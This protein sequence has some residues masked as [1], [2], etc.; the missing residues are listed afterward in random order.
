MIVG[1]RTALGDRLGITAPVVQAP[2]GS[3]AAP[4]LAAAV[5]EAGGLG[6]LAVTWQGPDRAR[7]S[8]REVRRRTS[9]P[10]GVNLILDFPVQDTL[11]VCL[12][13][14]VPVVSTFWGD[15]APVSQLI[16]DGGA[17]HMHTVGSVRE[18]QHSVDCDVDVIVAQGWEGGGHVRG[19]T[20]TMVL[21]P[22]VVDAVSP[23]PVMAAGGISDGRGVAAALA[24]GAQ[25]VWLGTRFLATIEARTHQ[26]YRNRLVASGA[27]DTVHTRCFDG[28][29]P[30]APHRVLRNT[31]VHRWESAGSPP[32]PG[33]PGD[34]DIV[35]VDDEGQPHHRYEDLIPLPGMTGDL[36]DMALY[37][38]QSVEL[39]RDV[40]PAGQLI[41]DLT[42][43]TID[44][45]EQMRRMT[46]PAHG[47]PQP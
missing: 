32:S 10:F 36:A 4:E 40:R 23:I 1:L 35:A 47:S 44:A 6:M 38:G 5:S 7:D 33:R 28:G 15:P 3:A 13:E 37:A 11:A 20:T 14:A 16:R 26:L 31:T 17:L 21:V 46:R 19:T 18:A 43:Q 9:R 12:D 39:V 2:V 34:G 25:G 24:L 8:I 22:A 27:E 29:W 30:D 42:T 45:I 41:R